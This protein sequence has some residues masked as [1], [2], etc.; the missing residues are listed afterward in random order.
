MSIMKKTISALL[1]CLMMAGINAQQI[2]ESTEN[3]PENTKTTPLQYAELIQT[4]DALFRV[5]HFLCLQTTSVCL[6]D[7]EPATRAEAAIYLNAIK[8]EK[9]DAT[10][11]RL[12]EQA[13]RYLH[14]QNYLLK[15]D[16]LTFDVNGEFALY[17]QYSDAKKM[18]LADQL[19]HYNKT[20]APVAVPL[21]I[22]LSPYVNLATYLE[23][24]KGFWA[25]QLSLPFTNMPLKMEALDV[26]IPHV[27]NISI[28]NSFM[29]FTIG[30]G[31]HNI[32]QT[33]NGSLF[34]ANS[35]HSLDF[36]SLRFFHKSVNI[37]SSIYVMERYR[38][39]FT[40]EVHFKI[41]DYVGVRLFEG[42][43]QYGSFDLRYLNPMMVIHNI[44]GW[45]EGKV[46]GLTPNGSQFGIGLEVVPY[47]GLRFYGQ[48]EMNQ[49]QTAYERKNYPAESALIPNSLG[50]LCGIEYAH[51]FPA[52]TLTFQSEF[53]YAN[54]WLNILENKKIS[55]LDKHTEKVKPQNTPDEYAAWLTNPL[56]PDTIAFVAKIG[57]DS[58]FRYGASL[59]YRFLVQGENGEKFFASSGDIYYPT[60][61]DEASIKTPSGNPLFVHTLSIEG[62]DEVYKNLT[63]R[64]GFEV[65]VFTGRKKQTAFHTYAGIEY[66][67]R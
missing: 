44:Y 14:K 35:T 16:Y 7:K 64:A 65:S 67:I 43:T 2:S 22:N 1:I 29:S 32:G 49:F 5:V 51:S 3:V 41:T 11:Q 34:L 27:A 10:G 26:H 48:F 36:A 55:L 57:V 4:D 25:S 21:T 56:G 38:Y 28:A 17:G 63:L 66:K 30:R 58:F 60:T 13:H 61:P 46:N 47:R 39:L 42:T 8:T 12:Y 62:F 9:L 45:D 59:Q 23:I 19:S 31:R 50:G 18:L 52:C 24:K 33:L 6:A 37:A 53:L 40:H 54:P 20:P 15:S